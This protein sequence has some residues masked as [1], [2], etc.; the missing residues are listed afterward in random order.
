MT[1]LAMIRAEDGI[2]LASDGAGYDPKTGRVVGMM[3]KVA[4]MP[5]LS[6]I[7]ASQGAGMTVALAQTKLRLIAS[8]GGPINGFDDVLTILPGIL[9]EIARND[10]RATDDRPEFV[11]LVGGYSDERARWETY[12]IHNTARC[13]TWDG[14]RFAAPYTLYPIPEAYFLPFPTDDGVTLSG[15]DSAALADGT[16]GPAEQVLGAVCAAR[17]MRDEARADG[18]APAH[19]VGGYLQLTMLGRLHVSSTIVHRWPDERG[20]LITPTADDLPEFLRPQP[21]AADRQP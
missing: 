4:L 3:S 2:V 14:G 9:C 15:I 6:C 17:F 8:V 19:V 18:A 10:L 11:V 21:T 16:F 12:L 1:A 20:E 5:D 13:A 7:L